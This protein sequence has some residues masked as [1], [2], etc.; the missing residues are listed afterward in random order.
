MIQILKNEDI[1]LEVDDDN[2]LPKAKVRAELLTRDNDGE[3]S[4]RVKPV[5]TVEPDETA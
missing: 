4:A 3:F 2:L 5:E 1:F